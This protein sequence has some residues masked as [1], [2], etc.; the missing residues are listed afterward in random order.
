MTSIDRTEALLTKWFAEEAANRLPDHL[1]EV[2]TA[3]AGIRQRSAWSS[4]GRWLPVDI[5][6]RASTL[7]PPRLGRVI[8]AAILIA[9]LVGLGILVAG[10]RQHR[11]PPPF[12]PAR[13]GVLLS[14]AD[15]DI[16]SV[17]PATGKTTPLIADPAFDFG[18]AF[19]PDGTRFLL[20][21]GSVQPNGGL[22]IAVANADGSNLRVITPYVDGLDW[23]DWSPD[24]SRVAYL[25]RTLGKGQINVVNVDGAD[26]R[27]LDVGQPVHEFLWLPPDGRDLIFRGDHR[28]D[29]DPPVAILAV[30]PDGTGLHTLSTRPP[31][32]PQDFESVAASP[33]GTRIAYRHSGPGP[34]S[35]HV[36]DLR[37]GMDLALPQPPDTAQFG[38]PFSPDGRSLLLIRAYPDNTVQLVV[39]PADGSGTGIALGPRAPFG[40]DGPTINNQMWAPDGKAVLANYDA[41]K[42]DR[43]LP[44]DGS[45]GRVLTRGDL[46]LPGYQRLA[47]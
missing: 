9:A 37:S 16:F 31:S 39:V 14:S 15:G 34:F 23:V 30:R 3:T 12:G 2:V 45:S 10:S 47:L 18:P 6:S 46:A 17:D 28:L 44:I 11:L 22:A 35:E 5:T 26:L 32:D 36:L 21:R 19:A 38:G 41:E 1:D 4:L 27:T 24:G 8:L 29:S 7:A 42:L 13:N 25:S 43:L 20:L 33:D 40:L